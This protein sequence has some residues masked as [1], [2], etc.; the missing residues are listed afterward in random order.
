MLMVVGMFVLVAVLMLMAFLF[1]LVHMLMVA[2]AFA[3]ACLSWRSPFTTNDIRDM[4]FVA[5]TI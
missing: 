3:D 5:P 4:L 1:V 2:D